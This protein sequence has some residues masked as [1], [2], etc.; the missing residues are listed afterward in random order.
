M[1]RNTEVT[2]EC[3]PEPR[4]GVYIVRTTAR[5]Q[6]IQIVKNI[7]SQRIVSVRL[8]IKI[9]MHKQVIKRKRHSFNA[10]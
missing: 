6:E 10:G 2:L 7:L 4:L 3:K 5:S 8:G 9:N 1:M